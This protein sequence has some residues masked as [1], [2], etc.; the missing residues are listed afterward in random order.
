VYPGVHNFLV[1]KANPGFKKIHLAVGLD[2]FFTNMIRFT[3]WRRKKKYVER[4]NDVQAGR[5]APQATLPWNYPC[6]TVSRE[7]NKEKNKKEVV[8]ILCTSSISRPPFTEHEL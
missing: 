2:L 7:E 5:H 8:L 1:R 3:I 6:T 4:G